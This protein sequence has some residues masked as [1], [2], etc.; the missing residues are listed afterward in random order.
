MPSPLPPR[1]AGKGN[2]A[3]SAPPPSPPRK[4]SRGNAPAMLSPPKPRK[5]SRRSM[6]T[7]W[8]V[9]RRLSAYGS[10][11]I[12]RGFS[13]EQILLSLLWGGTSGLPL[14]ALWALIAHPLFDGG[15]MTVPKGVALLGAMMCSWRHF[16]LSI[17]L[18]AAIPIALTVLTILMLMA[19]SWAEDQVPRCAMA[20]AST[21]TALQT[22]ARVTTNMRTMLARAV[23]S[24]SEMTVSTHPPQLSPVATTWRPAQEPVLLNPTATSWTPTTSFLNPAAAPWHPPGMELAAFV[25]A[26]EETAPTDADDDVASVA[27]TV[28]TTDTDTEATAETAGAEPAETPARMPPLT[29]HAETAAS[30]LLRMPRDAIRHIVKMLVHRMAARMPEPPPATAPAEVTPPATDRHQ[31]MA[32][33]ILA[34]TKGKRKLSD[35]PQRRLRYLSGRIAGTHGPAESIRAPAAPQPRAVRTV[36]DAPPPPNWR[37]YQ[38]TLSA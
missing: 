32:S 8:T 24:T 1:Q 11:A 38:L 4:A 29:T 27:A 23:A 17:A 14:T 15:N 22:V 21:R 26:M 19:L 37:Q 16:A 30:G 6:S 36:A 2:G 28:I 5:A 25:K 10:A 20:A 7:R 9:T 33:E 31:A 18:T 3:P 13:E 35:K 12:D 34:K